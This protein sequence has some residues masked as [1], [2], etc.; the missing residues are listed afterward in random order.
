MKRILTTLIFLTIVHISAFAT[1]QRA[2]AIIFRHISGFTYEATIVTYTYSL[3]NA[4]RCELEINWGDSTSE[5]VSR[6][7]GPYGPSPSGS[8][9]YLGEELGSDIKKNLYAAQHTYGG[10]G[11]YMISLEDPNRNG[12]V[13]N[14][15][16]SINVPFYIET[17][18]IINPF[19]GDNN[20]PILSNPPIDNACV[21][22][23]F[24]YNP[25]AFDVDIKDSLS[26]KLV[27]CRGAEGL[28]IPGYTYPVASNA[29]EINPVT[30]DLLWDSPT[31]NGEYNVAI[32]IEEW[33]DGKKIGFVTED[34]QITV[35]ACDN[36]PPVIQNITDTCVMAGDTLNIIVTAT[37]PDMDVITLTATG[38]PFLLP[39]S[40]VTFPQPVMGTGTVSSIFTWKTS[41]DHVKK[42]PYQV[43]FKARDNG[44]PVNL[45]DIESFQITV[46]SPAPENLTAS[47][48]GNNIKV[49]WNKC[50]CGNALG[51]KLY[52]R[53]IEGDCGFI[54]DTCETGVPSDMGYVL[55]A[56]INDIND[57]VYIDDNNGNGLIHGIDYG[58][59]VIAYFGDGAE[60]YASNEACTSLIRDVPIITNVSINKTD[61]VGGA[62]YVAWSKPTELDT[63]QT[64]GPHKYFIYRSSDYNGSNFTLI[65]SLY[66]SLDD[67]IYV[68]T[69]LNTRDTPLSYKIELY[70]DSTGNRFLI[71]P[72]HVASSVFLS[73][74][75]TDNTLNLSW[76]ENVPWVNDTFIVYR[77][78]PI[79]LNYD[80]IGWSDTHAY[81]DTG[82]TNG[83]QYCYLVKSV[84]GYSV[85]GIIDPII[86]Y[87][88]EDCESPLDTL[89]PCPPYLSVSTDCE[90]NTLVWN[91][92]NNACTNDVIRYIVYY[93]SVANSDFIPIQTITDPE[94]TTFI[95]SNIFS[96]AGCYYVTAVDSFNNE[97][98]FSNVV[99]LDIDLCPLYTLPNVFTPNGDGYNDKFVPFPYKYVERIDLKI[100]NRWGTTVFKTTNPDVNWDGKNQSNGKDCSE[101]V[102][103][104]ICDVYELRLQGL[105]KRTING[106]VHLLR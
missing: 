85:P 10:P 99:C 27:K 48:L 98:R 47:P 88:Q 83:N 11:V 26:Y 14:I 106:T 51:Y 33:R 8:N 4:D 61:P 44:S 97:S 6:Y 35:V 36:E 56:E 41:C 3:S 59:I 21:N 90:K 39:D 87:S 50:K 57:T 38:Y 102:Y 29:F 24:I 60:S 13:I 7:N 15:P 86:N 31:M 40:S 52:R 18:L 89:R 70:N 2:G 80:S 34:I 75:A 1:H 62:V 30:G 74:A 22:K 69:I 65:D 101:G 68:D 96:I 16:N 77:Q 82:L 92:P 79:T 37:D 46:I 20:S 42:S 104:Y 53:E 76:N 67:T 55:I 91:N 28:E 17:E 105:T 64:P 71:G 93:C 63:I 78:N 32:L 94:D 58:Y 103:F 43:V 23:P 9:C 100:F 12:G 5:Y 19:I 54:H 95:H 84:G 72:T 73:I 25:G 66:P 49:S 81:S 45:V